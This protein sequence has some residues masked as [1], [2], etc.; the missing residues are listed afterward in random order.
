MGS[1][2]LTRRMIGK[3]KIDGLIV[4]ISYCELGLVALRVGLVS[5]KVQPTG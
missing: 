1:S 2:M 3:N 5:R 4:V